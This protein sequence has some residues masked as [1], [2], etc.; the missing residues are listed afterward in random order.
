LESFSGN[1]ERKIVGVDNSLDEGEPLWDEVLTV[2]HDENSSDVE[3][4]VVLLL[5]VL[6]EVEW[7][8]LW[9][10]EKSGEFK[11]TLNGEMLDGEMLLP[12]VGKTLVEGNILI[13]GNILWL[14]HPDWLGLVEG[15]VLMRDLLDLLGLLLLL[16]ILILDLWLVILLLLV[17]LILFVLLLVLIRVSD[18]LIGGFLDH[19]LDWETDELRV[20]LD[21]ILELS[22]LEEFLLIFLELKDDLG[23]SGH[24]LIGLWVDGEGSTSV[25]F[26][27]VGLVIVVFGDNSDFLGNKISG[28]ESDTKLTNH[29]NVSTSS[30]GLHEGSSSRL[31]DGSEVIDKIALG[32]TNTRIPN[33]QGVVGLVWDD[34]DVKI[35]LSLK[36]FW[37]GNRVVSD[38]V[39]GIR[40]VR[41]KLSKE[42]L[43]V[44]VECVDNQTHQL[45]NISIES[46]NFFSHWSVFFGYFVN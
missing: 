41:D 19:E 35:W 37:L 46:K 30:D 26:P 27:S 31:G 5:L 38:L 16:F 17:F 8:S 45:L 22:L 11:L 40:C 7:S 43:L 15:F 39:K 24:G 3:L 42:D 21:E 23:T 1:V 12:I 33:G 44:G 32:H 18:L 14:S 20:L 9:N 36:L 34:P 25:R 2:V 13:S 6:E 29:A 28:V 10:K 4:E